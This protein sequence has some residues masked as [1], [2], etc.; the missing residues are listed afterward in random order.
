MEISNKDLRKKLKE[1]KLDDI[2]LIKGSGY[3]Y[4]VSDK[5]MFKESSIYVNSFNRQS[6]NKWIDDIIQLTT[7]SIWN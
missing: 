7:G 4:I 2:R 3:F 5:R 6:I 1:H